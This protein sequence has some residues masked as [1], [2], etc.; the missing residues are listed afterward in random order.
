MTKIT[1]ITRK[2]ASAGIAEVDYLAQ[3]KEF[4]TENTDNTIIYVFIIFL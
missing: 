2:M 4:T 3:A 1:R